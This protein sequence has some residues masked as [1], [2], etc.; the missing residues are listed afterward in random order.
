MKKLAKHLIKKLFF[1]YCFKESTLAMDLI[2]Y[3]IPNNIRKPNGDKLDGQYFFAELNKK[4][5]KLSKN[6]LPYFDTPVGCKDFS[7]LVEYKVYG[8]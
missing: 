4:E 2:C 1:K 8:E 6:Y 7:D 5:E 3:Y